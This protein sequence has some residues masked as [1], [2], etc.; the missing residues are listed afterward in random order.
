MLCM[1]TNSVYLVTSAT[2]YISRV[3]GYSLKSQDRSR[4]VNTDFTFLRGV[5][6][7]RLAP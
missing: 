5:Y 6:E 7:F 3:M 2:C 1:L 4:S